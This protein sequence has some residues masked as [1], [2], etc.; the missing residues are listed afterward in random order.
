M[1]L[2]DIKLINQGAHLALYAADYVLNDGSDKQYEFVSRA[3]ARANGPGSGSILDKNSFPD[4]KARGVIIM[5][6]NPKHDKILLMREFRPATGHVI[7]NHPMGLIDPGETWTETAE[8]ELK[9]ETGLDVINIV[10]VMLPAFSAPGISDQRTVTVIVEADGNIKPSTDP[11]EITEPFWATRDETM[12]ILA[13]PA[14]HFSAM[15]QA[16]LYAWCFFNRES[17]G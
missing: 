15:T 5:T 16:T 4:Q 3:G 6:F 8:R 9:E 13:S 12:R 1:E 2:R 7:F 11:N 10:T 17:E 14:N